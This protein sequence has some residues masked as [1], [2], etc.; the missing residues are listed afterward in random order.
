MKTNT[1]HYHQHVESKTYNKLVNIAK[2]K[3]T[4]KYREKTSG[5]HWKERK[6]EGKI[7]SRRLR[8][9]NDGV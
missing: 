8:I 3:Q 1:V 7:R 6:A 2:Q 4:H 5:Y 9:I